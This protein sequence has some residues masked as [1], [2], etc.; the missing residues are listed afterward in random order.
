M[1]NIK[2]ITI[3]AITAI[4]CI[5]STVYATAKYLASEVTYKNTTVESAL[6]ELYDNQGK[7]FASVFNRISSTQANDII[8]TYC[9]DNIYNYNDENQSI[10]LTKTGNYI[11]YIAVRTTSNTSNGVNPKLTFYLNDN[12]IISVTG[13]RTKMS[14]NAIKKYEFNAKA[15]DII[16]I[17][18]NGNGITQTVYAF[19]LNKIK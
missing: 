14:Y 6:N 13:D 19:T 11:L 17:S 3:I 12:E 16:T 1:K 2:T 4:V 8:D 5:S 10:E 18:H 7:I 15:G 9:I